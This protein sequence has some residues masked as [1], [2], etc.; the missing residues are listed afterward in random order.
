MTRK[1]GNKKSCERYKNEGRLAINKAR[2]MATQARLELKQ[3]QKKE[4]KDVGTN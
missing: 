3:K 1:G 4:L 2:R